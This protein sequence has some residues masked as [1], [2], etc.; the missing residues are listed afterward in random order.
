[1]KRKML[2]IL[3]IA[4]SL[5]FT[6]C[7]LGQ[8]SKAKDNTNFILSIS[9][10]GKAVAA[11][12]RTITSYDD[13]DIKLTDLS[14]NISFYTTDRVA[15]TQVIDN[16]EKGE[17]CF[18]YAL[19]EGEYIVTASAEFESRSSTHVLYGET[20]VEIV[21]GDVTPATIAVSLKKTE[22]GLGSIEN[23]KIDLSDIPENC[24]PT[25]SAELKAVLNNGEDFDL[26]ITMV[27]NILTLSGSNIPSDF[28]DLL[29]SFTEPGKEVEYILLDDSLVEIGDD[30]ELTG[31]K[32]ALDPNKNRVFFAQNDWNDNDY[33]GLTPNYRK[34][35][36]KIIELLKEDTT[37]KT[38]VIKMNEV[39]EIDISLYKEFDRQIKFEVNT[40]DYV[41]T[42]YMDSTGMILGEGS[43]SVK[44]IT[45]GDETEI[46]ILGMTGQLKELYLTESYLESKICVN[47]KNVNLESP[48]CVTVDANYLNSYYDVPFATVT[49]F[50]GSKELSFKTP[51]TDYACVS[52]DDVNF[53]TKETG[54]VTPGLDKFIPDYE[55]T[56]SIEDAGNSTPVTAG[57]TVPYRDISL[58]TAVNPLNEKEFLTGTKF[59]LWLN[60][61]N[62]LSNEESNYYNIT[63]LLTLDYLKIDAEN[64]IKWEI[65]YVDSEDNEHRES[66]SFKFTIMAVTERQ[67]AHMRVVD[68]ETVIHL[69][70]LDYERLDR[71]EILDEAAGV[72][73]DTY[74]LTNKLTFDSS[75]MDI[76][77]PFV[78]YSSD[79]KKTTLQFY[80]WLT[81]EEMVSESVEWNAG[82]NKKLNYDSISQAVVETDE[83]YVTYK[84]YGLDEAKG[85]V[86]NLDVT[87]IK[88][89]TDIYS[90]NAII[91]NNETWLKA[92]IL[93][94]T[95]INSVEQIT[96]TSNDDE[97]YRNAF[98]GKKFDLIAIYPETLNSLKDKKEYTVHSYLSF[99]LDGWDYQSSNL[100]G[101][102]R[103]ELSY[104]IT[105]HCTVQYAGPEF[106]IKDDWKTLT[107]NFKEVPVQ[108][109]FNINCDIVESEEDWG[110]KYYTD[111]LFDYEEGSLSFTFK[112]DECLTT[113]KELSGNPDAK[114]KVA[115]FYSNENEATFVI[116]SIIATKNDGTEELLP[117]PELAWGWEIIQ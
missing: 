2:A 114:L 58:K 35:L 9:K 77:W 111:Y 45:T 29:I 24:R 62:L 82:G 74:N 57:G 90:G 14:W 33:N 32:K 103:E 110:T 46:D 106:S 73:L 8:S 64:I 56:L 105:V 51:T 20:T 40:E 92:E 96:G 13:E 23:F 48:L 104:P 53:Y 42:F 26:S 27:G 5:F 84:N 80:Y 38:A 21:S 113:L 54:P 71:F 3:T 76:P 102:Y 67:S 39:P 107:I 30:E 116:E 12:A 63:D 97:F 98:N 7:N 47:F 49:K 25:A 1:M 31:S 70:N 60:E 115:T 6:A 69:Q 99:E 112:L 68:G 55:I 10:G 50:A 18:K 4:A 117:I 61:K 22:L 34:S 100:S 41:G 109:C 37:W 87:K 36:E 75:E 95:D 65:L 93:D 94:L 101:W 108:P 52:Y 44:F 43:L 15:V 83:Y 72:S 78:N 19:P 79:S 11:P 16:S 66:S 17:S 81:G 91:W 85:L 89:R 88:I 59:S 86:N 28:Y